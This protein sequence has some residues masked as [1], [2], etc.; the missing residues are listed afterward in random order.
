M[1]AALIREYST[2]SERAGVAKEL[3]KY[4]RGDALSVTK[5]SET[6]KKICQDIWNRQKAALSSKSGPPALDDADAATA[7]KEKQKGNE[8]ES[9]DD[10]DF[11]DDIE[12]ALISKTTMVSAST[13]PTTEEDSKV[14]LQKQEE[15]DEKKELGAFFTTLTSTKTSS[16]GNSAS[17]TSATSSAV[18]SKRKFHVGFA[19]A[20]KPQ[21]QTQDVTDPS[22]TKM[23]QDSSANIEESSNLAAWRI[24]WVPPKRVVKR[25]TTVIKPDGSETVK[26]EYIIADSQEL[27]KVEASCIK[28]KKERERRSL[29]SKAGAHGEEDD[30]ELGITALRTRPNA[31]S[32]NL[33]KM[34]KAVDTQTKKDME[35]NDILK[36]AVVLKPK[37]AGR[38]EPKNSRG[39]G[40]EASKAKSGSSK[41]TSFAA[42]P[43]IFRA[44]RVAFAARLEN[45]IM[46]L[47][48]TKNAFH[49]YH[50]VDSIPGYTS[51]VQKPICLSDIREKIASYRYETAA[52]LIDD[53]ELMARNS[54]VF[55]G[56]ESPVT[57]TAYKLLQ[58]LTVSLNH[59]KQH[60]GEDKDTIRLLEDAIK[61]RMALKQNSG[62]ES[63]SSSAGI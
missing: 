57:I 45:E 61:K 8:D 34:K 5:E 16:A 43:V 36:K 50:P 63:S 28:A 21:L 15:E 40:G 58:K 48:R 17:T 9:D 41:R 62:L 39:S 32:I 56:K 54:E 38:G 13:R 52:A 23:S 47:W 3:H 25:T 33:S 55:N 59:E 29:T 44:A 35:S 51:K 14:Q 31:M 10:S 42:K 46:E 19:D 24:G 53:V 12:K 18:T 37:G 11:A 1:Q 30:D 7:E 2:Q 20:T 6:Y 49:F 22:G 60:L 4:A 26:V 27:A